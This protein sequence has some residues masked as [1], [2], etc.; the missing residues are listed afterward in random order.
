MPAPHRVE[1]RVQPVHLGQ[2]RADQRQLGQ[3]G[4]GE[5]PGAQAVVQVVVVIGDVVGHRR[6]LR[7]GAG[8]GVE[9]QVPVGVDLGQRPGPGG[10]HRAVVLGDAFER[11]PRQVEAVEAGVVAFQPGHDPQR[12]GVV[13][14]A[15]VWRHQRGERILSGVAEGRVAE[16][17]GQ[18]HRLGQIGVE[19]ERR[20]DGAGDLRHLDRVGQAGAVIVAAIPVAVL[21]DE[22]LGLVL[23]PAEGRRVDDPVAVAL[24]GR[25]EGGQL[26]RVAAAAARLRAA[27]EGGE[28]AGTGHGHL[29][30]GVGGSRVP[31]GRRS[32]DH[33]AAGLSG[34]VPCGTCLANL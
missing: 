3:V 24:P 26:L 13:V 2:R 7:L 20:G 15:A 31:A 12:L 9:P 30:R 23:E 29:G 14:E 11:F 5:E 4:L 27:G 34:R 25:A 33:A 18:R 22:H 21:F 17:V 32:G 1:P 10:G 8:M 6:H 28:A 19:P 16:V